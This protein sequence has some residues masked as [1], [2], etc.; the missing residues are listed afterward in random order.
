[1]KTPRSTLLVG[2]GAA[3]LVG[4]ALGWQLPIRGDSFQ[5]RG[6]QAYFSPDGGTERALANLIRESRE[7]VLVAMYTMTNSD[8]GEALETAAANGRRVRV[9]LDD[10]EARNRYSQARDLAKGSVELRRVRMPLGPEDDPEMGENPKFHHKFMVVDG[11]TVVVGSYNWTRGA[12]SRNA[13]STLVL[14]S[15]KLAQHFRAEFLAAWEG[16]RIGELQLPPPD[17][18]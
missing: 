11:R 7:E 14:Q 13:E 4:M 17:E 8:L 3:L 10:T 18:E 5:S 15:P 1:M 12:E 2:W 16:R 9:L 6:V